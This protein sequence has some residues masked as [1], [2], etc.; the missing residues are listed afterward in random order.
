MKIGILTLPLDSNY[1]G[2]LQTFAL[3]H[4]LRRNGHEVQL[5]RREHPLPPVTPS[6][7]LRRI[8]N[9]FKC[10]TL[11]T[12][13]SRPHLR[14]M[15][16]FAHHYTSYNAER[17]LRQFQ[18][19]HILSSR[20]IYTSGRLHAYIRKS[21]FDAIIVGSDQVWREDY[22]PCITDY[23]L[24]F[25]PAGDP[26]RRLAYAASFG[27]ETNFISPSSLPLCIQGIQRF[28]AVSVREHSG[29]RIARQTF[30]IDA[31]LTLDPTLLL[32]PEE[33]LGLI[34]P[35]HR[36][37]PRHITSYILDP[38][39]EKTAIAD[40]AA[41]TKNLPLVSLSIDTRPPH[42]LRPVEFWLSA[43][44]SAEFVIT[45]SYHGAVFSIIFQRSFIVIA[46]TH[47]GIDRFKTLLNPLGLTN[48]LIDQS[49][50]PATIR[51]LLSTPIDFT[52]IHAR[53]ESLRAQSSR[54]LLS[55]L[56][57]PDSS[58]CLS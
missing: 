30:G 2:I 8:A 58:T 17:H 7:L 3:Q 9:F 38:T 15:N 23:F 36:T 32:S 48:R 47:R 40:I 12:L 26:V 34:Q 53:L 24:T 18:N 46:N 33:Y 11:K 13:S 44:S 27:K 50:H 28:N 20:P 19:R 37:F 25:L 29:L 56:S 16:P 5:I 49:T 35:A 54:W 52:A 57:T 4:L 14:I 39:P 42:I 45:D 55:N 6:L 22:S 41:Q 31:A 21:N 43:I 10:L 51:Q 1:G